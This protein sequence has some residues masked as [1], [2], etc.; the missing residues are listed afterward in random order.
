MKEYK[1]PEIELLVIDNVEEILLQS[2][3]GYVPIPWD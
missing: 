1:K 2:Q 3:G